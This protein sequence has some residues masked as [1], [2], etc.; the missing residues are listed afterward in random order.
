[1]SNSLFLALRVKLV[2]YVSR[3]FFLLALFD[4]FSG[5]T[6]FFTFPLDISS[7][8]FCGLKPPNSPKIDP[9]GIAPANIGLTFGFEFSSD[10]SFD[11][12]S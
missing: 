1:M 6:F 2:P 8:E 10:S 11:E 5:F 7:E 4:F 9:K 3:Y 12:L